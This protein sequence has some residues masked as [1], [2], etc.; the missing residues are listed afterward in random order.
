MISVIRKKV[1]MLLT[2]RAEAVK[3]IAPGNPSGTKENP[4]GAKRRKPVMMRV[5]EQSFRRPLTPCAFMGVHLCTPPTA[6]SSGGHEKSMP[7][8]QCQRPGSS[9][10]GPVCP[11]SLTRRIILVVPSQ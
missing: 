4:P 8:N 7:W 6:T 5:S 10:N 3:Q 9:A 2:V 11:S 1:R